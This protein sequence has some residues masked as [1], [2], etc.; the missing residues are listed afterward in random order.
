MERYGV[1]DT[2]VL[3]TFEDFLAGK[4]GQQEAVLAQQ[5]AAQLPAERKP[6]EVVTKV[7]I[8]DSGYDMRVGT[9]LTRS[10]VYQQQ[11]WDQQAADC[12]AMVPR[13][14]SWQA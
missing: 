7:Q 6:P 1:A 9:Q 10:L 4:C 11:D 8:D 3:I 5:Q 14:Q 12:Y 13:K 2:D